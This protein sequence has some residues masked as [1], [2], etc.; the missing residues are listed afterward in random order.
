MLHTIDD[1]KPIFDSL[2]E[3][4]LKKEEGIKMW[5]SNKYYKL[6]KGHT[7][8]GIIKHDWKLL[9]DW[10]SDRLKEV[11]KKKGKGHDWIVWFDHN[12]GKFMRD[13]KISKISPVKKIDFIIIAYMS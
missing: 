11:K 2:I 7:I 13:N 5:W 9:D 6:K 10:Y 8:A 3:D 1:N 4:Y 12:F